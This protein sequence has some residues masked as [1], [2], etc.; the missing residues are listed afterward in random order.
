MDSRRH[1]VVCAGLAITAACSG[2]G[3]GSATSTE[4]PIESRTTTTSGVSAD[5][6]S[7]ELFSPT[8][9]A[10]TGVDDGRDGDPAAALYD[11]DA[12]HTFDLVVEPD[13]L[14]FLDAD[15]GAEEYVDGFLEFGGDTYGPIGVRYKGSFGSF[16]GCVDELDAPDRPRG[17]DLSETVA[18]TEVRR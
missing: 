6:P 11:Q 17:E 5:E 3:A 13:D 10:P 15:P 18:Q 8:D 9:V 12:V 2:G 7:G 1:L 4:P 16:V 14:A